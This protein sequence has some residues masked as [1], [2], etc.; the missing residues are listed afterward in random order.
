MDFDNYAEVREFADY[1]TICGEI[2]NVVYTNEETGY[3]VLEIDQ[4]N[5]GGR[6]TVVG[7]IPYP[8]EGER[9]IA[10][11]NFVNHMAYGSQF[12]AIRTER[13]MPAS[14]SALLRYLSLGASKG[15]H[16]YRKAI[17]DRFKT[18]ALYYR[19]D[20]GGLPK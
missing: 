3:A 8:G 14:L 15:R 6:V 7:C 11:G 13:M 1:V 2:E 19:I 9:I 18:K 20:P 4:E 10:D 5:G 16:R 17:V 12:K